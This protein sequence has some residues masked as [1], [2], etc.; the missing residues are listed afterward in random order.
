MLMKLVKAVLESAS[1]PTRVLTGRYTF[2]V[3]NNTRN[4]ADEG[5]LPHN[6]YEAGH[7]WNAWSEKYGQSEQVN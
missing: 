5:D 4:V 3:G 1:W 2:E 6:I 7:G